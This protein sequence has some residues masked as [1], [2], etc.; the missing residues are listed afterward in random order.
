MSKVGSFN[1][2]WLAKAAFNDSFEWTKSLKTTFPELLKSV[3]FH[4]SYWQNIS[5]SVANEVTLFIKLDVFWNKKYT[6][7]IENTDHWPFLLIKIPD[8][9]NIAYNAIDSITTISEASSVLISRNEVVNLS[10]VA[11]GLFSKEYANRLFDCKSLHRTI[12]TD[13]YGGCVEILHAGEIHVLLVEEDGTYIDP[14]LEKATVSNKP[15][16]HV[17]EKTGIATSW[18]KRLTGK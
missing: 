12:F 10:V 14:S 16:D 6:L 7:R 1:P 3:T 18:W 2:E 11:P 4:D 13:I 5:L 8:V 15:T 9:I 17:I